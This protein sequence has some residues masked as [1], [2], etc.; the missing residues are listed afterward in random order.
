[1]RGPVDDASYRRTDARAHADSH[2]LAKSKNNNR[3]EVET[4]RLSCA[5]ASACSPAVRRCL[6][7]HPGLVALGSKREVFASSAVFQ[8]LPQPRSTKVWVLWISVHTQTPPTPEEHPPRATK[9]SSPPLTTPKPGVDAFNS[10]HNNG[11]GSK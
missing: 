10:K 8:I 7:R 5:C 9:K 1:M 4:S 3:F 6:R 11:L 2:S